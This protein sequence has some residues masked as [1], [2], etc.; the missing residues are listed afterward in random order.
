MWQTNNEALQFPLIRYTEYFTILDT[1]ASGFQF[2][3]KEAMYIKGEKPI[4][5]QHVIYTG[6][7]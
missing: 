4:L 5:N 3:V 6:M 1:A 7:C 2:K